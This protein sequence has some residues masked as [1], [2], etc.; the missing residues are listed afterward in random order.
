[1]TSDKEEFKWNLGFDNDRPAD[2]I[3]DRRPGR[4]EARYIDD[5]DETYEL[6][7]GFEARDVPRPSRIG[8]AIGTIVMLGI[9]VGLIFGAVYAANSLSKDAVTGLLAGKL[10]TAFGATDEEQ[11]HIEF[12]SGLFI[13]QAIKGTLEDVEI[14]IDDAVVGPLTGDLSISAKGVPVDQSGPADTIDVSVLLNEENVQ[15][16]SGKFNPDRKVTLTVADGVISAKSSISSPGGSV[17]IVVNY[18]PS[19]EKGK[20]VLRPQTIVVGK[21]AK[22]YTVEEFRAS[23]YGTVG[24]ALS[25]KRTVCVANLLPAALTLSDA[26]AT[27]NGFTLG[28][29]G[30]KVQLSGAALTAPGTCA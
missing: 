10:Q 8:R 11:V 26:T 19:A 27:A 25:K 17:P 22:E 30:S 6:P 14:T 12:G 7:P 16:I 24:R 28:A 3:T 15:A 18:A 21:S 2:R 5:A 20:L 23:S 9:L 4:N 29:S 13:I 1:M